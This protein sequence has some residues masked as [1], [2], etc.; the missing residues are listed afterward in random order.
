MPHYCSF[1][2]IYY[3]AAYL[4]TLDLILR[5]NKKKIYHKMLGCC[6]VS[7]M[8]H[9]SVGIYFHLHKYLHR[10]NLSLKEILMYSILT[11]GWI[12]SCF[13]VLVFKIWLEK[14]V[15]REN[16]KIITFVFVSIILSI[17]H[18]TSGYFCEGFIFSIFVR[19]MNSWK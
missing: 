19:T 9:T 10:V 6:L 17:N 3:K 5:C 14:E 13:V 2:R 7:K 15:W 16:Y 18:S 8:Y 12:S 11:K 4:W 1:S